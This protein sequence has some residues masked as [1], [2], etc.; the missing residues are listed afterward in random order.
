[1]SKGSVA[2]ARHLLNSATSYING[3]RIYPRE[4]V[5][6]DTVLL[7]LLS[8][9]TKVG[10]AVCLLVE[11]G[12]DDEAFGLT[13]TMIDLALSARYITNIDSSAR[14]KRYIEYFAKD[15]EGWTK[16]IGKYFSDTEVEFPSDHD[17]RLEVAKTFKSPHSWT[18]LG[19]QT[20]E[21]AFEEDLFEKDDHGK[22]V[23]W[24]FDYEVTYKWTSHFVHGTIVAMDRHS[25]RSGNPFRVF[26]GRQRIEKGGMALFNM[27]IYLFKAFVVS[28]RGMGYEVNEP[29]AK[30]FNQT[31]KWLA[32]RRGAK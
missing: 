24:E 25:S 11:G 15:H 9:S 12:Y 1:M 4:N 23:K 17:R 20:R 28:L 7:T 8:K 13:R 19:S 18:G 27:A 6:S 10:E 16:I 29:L 3:L 31:I 21:M 14:A 22:P 30:D 5:L 32:K 2:K 26:A